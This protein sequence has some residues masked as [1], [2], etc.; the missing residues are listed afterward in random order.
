MDIFI[1][2]AK[3]ALTCLKRSIINGQRKPESEMIKIA[4][5]IFE[6]LEAKKYDGSI[7]E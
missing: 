5:F 1:N 3:V 4:K 6:F 7:I 2:T